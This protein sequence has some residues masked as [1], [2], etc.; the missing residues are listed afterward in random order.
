MSLPVTSKN[1]RWM[2][3]QRGLVA[4]ILTVHAGLLAWSAWVHAP[5]VDEPAHLSAGLSHWKKFSFDLYRVNPPLVRM[6]AAFPILFVSHEEDWS[7]YSEDLY[8]RAEFQVGTDFIKANPERYRFLLFLARCFCIPLSVLGGYICYRFG[9]E[10]FGRLAGL[11]SLLLWCF[12]P[13]IL[14]F[15]YVIMPDVGSAA[16]GIL[17]FYVFYH[18]LRAPDWHRC[19][20]TGIALGLAQLTKFTLL[21]FYPMMIGLWGLHLFTVRKAITRQIGLLQLRQFSSI[22]LISLAVIHFGYGFE[23]SFIPLKEFE[24]VSRAMCGDTKWN[25]ATGFTPTGNRFRETWLGHLPVPVPANYLLG[26]DVQKKDFEIGQDSYFFGKWSKEGWYSYYLIGLLIKE[27]LGFWLLF[28]MACTFTALLKTY[29]TNMGTEALLI[30]PVLVILVLI[31]SQTK[32]NHHLRY[33]IPILPFLFIFTSRLTKYVEKRRVALALSCF[34]VAWCMLSSLCF[35]PHSQAY[36]SVLIGR[37]ENA[38]KYL[39]GSNIDWGQDIFYLERWCRKNPEVAELKVAC[40]GSFPLE[41]TS[42][43]STGMPPANDPQPGWYAVSVNYLYDREKQYRYFLNFE[44]VARAG[45]SI[46]IYHVTLEEANRVRNKMGL[47]EL[48][49]PVEP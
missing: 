12:S 29:R 1:P 35:Y 3:W 21:T 43:L 42:I 8:R 37:S 28:V 30:V 16:L 6:I 36:F 11:F 4:L 33:A 47:P 14:A 44:L 19:C 31:S 7:S 22:L 10:L 17:A 26:I 46:Y 15:G 38:P 13:M 23:G 39:L 45:Y 24:F 40:W 48:D 9:M 49:S 27:P 25:H 18:W 5:L 20:F 34:L 32:L 2:H 41:N